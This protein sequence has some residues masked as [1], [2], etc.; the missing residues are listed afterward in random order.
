MLLVISQAIM[1]SFAPIWG[2][3]AF[4]PQQCRD[5]CAVPN[6]KILPNFYQSLEYKFLV[7]AHSLHSFYE[8]FKDCREL[9]ERSSVKIWEDSCKCF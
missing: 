4:H 3:L 5:E 9:Y 6:L 8:I 2:D 1:R 7:R